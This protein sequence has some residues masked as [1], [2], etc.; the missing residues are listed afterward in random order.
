M[1]VE[2]ADPV[3][4][5]IS[6]QGAP[7]SDCG[8]STYR[9]PGSLPA[10]LVTL[11]GVAVVL[12]YWRI[13]GFSV[14][15]SDVANYWSD[16]VHWRDPFSQFHVPGYALIL[17][18]VRSATGD[19]IPP[20]G[21][22][23]LVTVTALLSG[24]HATYT[25]ASHTGLSRRV[26]LSAASA[27]GLW[28]FVGVTYA[29]FPVSDP[30]ALALLLWG[31]VFLLRER[32]ALAG[33][34]FGLTAVTHKA[35]WPAVGLL[36][37]GQL[38]GSARRR[39][40]IVIAGVAAVPLLAYWVYGIASGHSAAWL[41][42]TSAEDAAR[43]AGHRA[44]HVL[45]GLVGSAVYGDW[46]GRA[47]V[48]VAVGMLALAVILLVIHM[49]TRREPVHFVVAVF[50]FQIIFMALSLNQHLIWASV[51]FS[52][53]LAFPTAWAVSR[54]ID[55]CRPSRWRYLTLVVTGLL[56]ATQVL[57]AAEG[58]RRQWLGVL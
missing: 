16:S 2:V 40:G 12:G 33:L 14:Y 50:S 31:V 5:P 26:S 30:V 53:L 6:D 3:G 48:G 49:S 19:V 54:A 22:M 25:L 27:F 13:I 17:T 20:T 43:P 47:R 52:G 9:L 1:P 51:R 45:D 38:V 24:V 21:L 10:L 41:M 36:V 55:A 11:C 57:T 34:A 35:L 46:V 18:V 56:I 39:A 15:T 32:P 23:T 37:A 7:V 8:A 29:A 58:S 28:P 42:S 4:A 44:L